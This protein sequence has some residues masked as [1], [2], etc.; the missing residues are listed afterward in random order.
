MT[1]ECSDKMWKFIMSFMKD[2][3]ESTDADLYEEA[4][5]IVKKQ[6]QAQK[7][8][9]DADLCFKY[10]G[11]AFELLNLVA[12]TNQAFRDKKYGAVLTDKYALFAVHN[13]IREE[14]VC[15]ADTTDVFL[16]WWY[17]SD[18]DLIPGQKVPEHVL[19]E[20]DRRWD[21]I[22]RLLYGIK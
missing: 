12:A 2:Y 20:I 1:I 17:G 9:I 18:F 3:T 11:Q 21:E 8:V 13:D 22:Q 15:E 14:K 6:E 10:R 5:E 4:C 19:K 16:D 7:P